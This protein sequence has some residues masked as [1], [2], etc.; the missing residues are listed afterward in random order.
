MIAIL[1]NVMG[2]KQVLNKVL[3]LLRDTG[4][5]WIKVCV[6]SPDQFGFPISRE[7]FFIILISR[8]VLKQQC[9]PERLA[10]VVVE[11]M[12]RHPHEDFSAFLYPPGHEIVQAYFAQGCKGNLCCTRGNCACQGL[13]EYGSEWDMT[14][15]P[16]SRVRCR[17]RHAHW[18]YMLRNGLS[19]A[20][21]ARLGRSMVSP[22]VTS[23]RMQHVLA[24]KTFENG[25]GDCAKTLVVDISQSLAHAKGRSTD[26]L[27][28]ITPGSILF[29]PS[30]NRPVLTEDLLV[31]SFAVPVCDVYF[32]FGNH[33]V[34]IM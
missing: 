5:W 16:P 26:T 8:R 30:L 24:I 4:D 11:C 10:D 33:N 23:P 34:Y 28:V 9:D 17:W 7:R 21:V 2:L 22:A 3:E 1:E 15:P 6:F 14:K 19:P 13:P 31:T 25:G 27:Q 32:L 20:K 29:L 12:K 18:A